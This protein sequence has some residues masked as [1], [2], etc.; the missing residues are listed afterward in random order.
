M[1]QRQSSRSRRYY[2]TFSEI[3]EAERHRGYHRWLDTRSSAL[4][5]PH[6]PGA[7]VLEVGCGTGL[8]LRE[9]APMAKHA[10]G[11]DLSFGMLSPAQQRG[12]DVVQASATEIPF[13]DGVFDLVYS[14]KVLA[15]VPDIATAVREMVRVTRPGGR[16]LLEFYNRASLRYVIRRLRRPG[17]V[18]P[19]TTEEDVFTRFD[20]LRELE[21]LLPAGARLTGVEGLRV[22]TLAPQLFK[23]PGIGPWWERLE[24]AL[25]RSPLKRLAG[26]LVLVIEKD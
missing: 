2:D 17:H 11:L 19:G 7:R 25:S 26:F 5:R 24:D 15:H 8:I 6:L 3:Y 16:L 22:A 12:L 1:S 21:A 18:G 23:L 13:A 4:L 9:V 14:F 10:V 20:S